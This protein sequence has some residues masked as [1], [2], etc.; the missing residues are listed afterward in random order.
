MTALLNIAVNTDVTAHNVI[1][2]LYAMTFYLEEQE[3]LKNAGLA[4]NA[5]PADPTDL[6]F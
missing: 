6:E 1:V 5:I 2:I 3:M 4:S